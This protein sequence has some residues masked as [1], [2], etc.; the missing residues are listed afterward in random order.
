MPDHH[1]P[2][3]SLMKRTK[4]QDS[5]MLP[6]P[7]RPLPCKSGRTTGPSL[8][9]PLRTLKPT[10]QH[11]ANALPTTQATTFCLISPGSGLLSVEKH[12]RNKN[13]PKQFLPSPHGTT[14]I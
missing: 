12:S 2:F 9:A 8:R 14:R 3:F 13:K 4:N 11:E 5:K 6:L 1:T 10:L 7:H